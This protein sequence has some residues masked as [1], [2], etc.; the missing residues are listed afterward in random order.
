[1]SIVLRDRGV[2]KFVKYVS[3]AAKGDRWDVTGA[4]E[5]D[6]DDDEEDDEEENAEDGEGNGEEEE[7]EEEEEDEEEWNGFSD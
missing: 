4:F 2:L 3:K 6:D 5:V 1:M 7:E